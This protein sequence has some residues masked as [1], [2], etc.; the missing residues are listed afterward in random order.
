MTSFQ[1]HYRN[2]QGTLMR[3]LAA[4]F[5]RGLDICY[6]EARPSGHHHRVDLLVETNI[7]SSSARCAVIGMRLWM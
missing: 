3:I 5:R 6:L 4:V 7:L 1:I 2:T